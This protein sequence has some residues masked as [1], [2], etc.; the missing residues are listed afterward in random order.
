METKDKVRQRR[1]DRIR[2]IQQSRT[3]HGMQPSPYREKPS[4]RHESGLPRSYEVEEHNVHYRDMTP[5]V[6]PP[7]SYE[8][9]ERRLYRRD[10]AAQG[11]WNDPEFV[12]NQKYKREWG[13][14]ASWNELEEEW[15]EP[16]GTLL[17]R[18]FARKKMLI[19]A[20]LFGLVWGIFQ[21]NHPL[22][23]EAKRFIRTSLTESKPFDKLAVWYDKTFQGAP[24]FIPRFWR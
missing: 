20:I 2:E 18:N 17:I 9:D 10:E 14:A 11:D 5:Q 21:V 16:S 15:E 19:S 22:A 23:D 1:T 24:S 8:T 12:W 7:R 6:G 13:A 4:S 3:A